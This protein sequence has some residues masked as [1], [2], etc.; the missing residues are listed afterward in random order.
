MRTQSPAEYGIGRL[1]GPA[2]E[3]RR[4]GPL[5]SGEWRTRGSP[6]SWSPTCL[7]FAKFAESH[8]SC[9]ASPHWPGSQC[10]STNQTGP[11]TTVE[12]TR[13]PRLICPPQRLLPRPN[14]LAIDPSIRPTLRSLHHPGAP[15]HRPINT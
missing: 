1:S 8:M 5:S 14:T 11:S 3:P 6:R 15:P 12:P 4:S 10:F 9:R 7:L 13:T 2:L